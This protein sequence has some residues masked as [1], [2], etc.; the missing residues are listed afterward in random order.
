MESFAMHK[1]VGNSEISKKVWR[2]DPNVS[3]GASVFTRDR[4]SASQLDGNQNQQTNRSSPRG[5]HFLNGEPGMH[6][7]LQV[8]FWGLRLDAEGV[9]AIM[10]AL[11]IVTAFALLLAL[12]F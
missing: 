12:R 2:N 3:K 9:I 10:A 11:L 4:T 1:P 5:S 6:N 7:R 8:S